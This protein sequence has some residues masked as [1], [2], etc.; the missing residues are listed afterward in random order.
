MAYL[1]TIYLLV[2]NSI[3]Y[4]TMGRDKAYARR[5]KRRVPEARLFGIALLGGA[6]GIYIGMY[7]FHHKT[8][9][10]SFRIGIPLLLA[11]HT[12]IATYL[13]VT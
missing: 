7:Q 10:L 5:N 3:G 12:A 8:K 6:L 4:V 11:L 13:Y 1:L 2:M 9:H